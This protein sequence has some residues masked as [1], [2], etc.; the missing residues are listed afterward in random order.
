M[1]RVSSPRT[2]QLDQ[3]EKLTFGEVSRLVV[4]TYRGTVNIVATDGPPTLEVSRIRGRAINVN[5]RPGR[6]EIDH[7]RWHPMQVFRPRRNRVGPVDLTIAIPRDCVVSADLVAS[8]GVISGLRS[9]VR[10]RS[11]SG[12]LTIVNV[13]GS[14]D[15]HTV[16]GLIEA[17]QLRG[18]LQVETVS[19]DIMLMESAADV[20]AKSVSGAITL[21]ANGRPDSSARLSTVSGDITVQAPRESDVTVSFHSTSGHIVTAFDE[22]ARADMPGMHFVS[23]VLGLGAGKLW[24]SST[25]GNIA[26]LRRESSDDDE[27][28]SFISGSEEE[29]S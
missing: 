29:Q 6:L 24:A 4:R 14:I 20:L 11:V 16:S 12:A 3:P 18:D 26:L 27:Q 21:A 5:Y 7:G 10:L 15:A 13:E 17:Q 2:F 9:G 28:E 19:G 8:G 1:D 23:G 25:S 22:L